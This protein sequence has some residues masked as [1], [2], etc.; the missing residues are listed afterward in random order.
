MNNETDYVTES[1]LEKLLY[2]ELKSQQKILDEQSK[3]E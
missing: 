1:E 3:S 2:Q